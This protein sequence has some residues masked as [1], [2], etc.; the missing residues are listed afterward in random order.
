VTS[1][2]TEIIYLLERKCFSSF[3]CLHRLNINW[4]MQKSLSGSMFS[5]TDVSYIFLCVI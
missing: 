2:V 1:L 4:Q 5:A 3:P